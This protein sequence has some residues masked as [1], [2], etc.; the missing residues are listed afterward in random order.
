MSIIKRYIDLKELEEDISYH[1]SESDYHFEQFLASREEAQRH[2]L[3]FQ[4]HQVYH[5]ELINN[6]KVEFCDAISRR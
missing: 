5:L 4:E 1:A 6:L 3:K 2:L